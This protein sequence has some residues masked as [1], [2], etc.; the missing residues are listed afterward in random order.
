VAWGQSNSR[1]CCCQDD[2]LD[3]PGE[4]EQKLTKETEGV[5]GHNRPRAGVDSVQLTKVRL[6]DSA[7]LAVFSQKP[8]QCQRLA[9]NHQPR[10]SMATRWRIPSEICVNQI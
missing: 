1:Q 3:A 8:P 10:I 2:F 7:Q 5:V 6:E 9:A 4:F